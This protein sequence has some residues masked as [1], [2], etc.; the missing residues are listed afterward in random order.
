MLDMKELTINI[1]I[2]FMQNI[3]CTMEVTLPYPFGAYFLYNYEPH[4]YLSLQIFC[5][6]WADISFG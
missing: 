2:I 4:E 3:P 6:Q 1:L 5:P